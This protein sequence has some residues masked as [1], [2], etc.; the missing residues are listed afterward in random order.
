ML[1]KSKRNKDGPESSGPEP[2]SPARN[3]SDTVL[4]KIKARI[5]TVDE[6]EISDSR[7]SKFVPALGKRRDKKRH[8]A[9]KSTEDNTEE[10]HGRTGKGST[11]NSLGT[12]ESLSTLNDERSSL[13]TSDSEE[14]MLVGCFSFNHSICLMPARTPIPRLRPIFA[15]YHLIFN[16]G[17]RWL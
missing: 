15:L 16:T 11:S 10:F 3:S 12:S 6:E 7:I 17:Y 5:G 4:G 1:P 13:L 2:G 8:R 9:R 14:E